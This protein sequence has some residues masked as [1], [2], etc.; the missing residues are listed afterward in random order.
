MTTHN[1][2]ASR[3][4]MNNAEVAQGGTVPRQGDAIMNTHLE[5]L[6]HSGF[7]QA[8]TWSAP[9]VAATQVSHK[10]E[11]N[12]TEFHA[13]LVMPAGPQRDA[14]AMGLWDAGMLVTTFSSP[15]EA[16]GVLIG[17]R[18][19][20]VLVDL[21]LGPT[22]GPDI[23]RWLQATGRGGVTVAAFGEATPELAQWLTTNGVTW[24]VPR[25]AEPTVFGRQLGE[26]MGF[27]PATWR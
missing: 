10:L 13:V 16:E 14:L 24:C 2:Q 3:P 15:H 25:P 26:A 23:V 1:V 9:G 21:L 22:M 18:V 11:H 20:V 27:K 6:A 19:H 17:E 4:L 8:T 7:P 12:H 5:S